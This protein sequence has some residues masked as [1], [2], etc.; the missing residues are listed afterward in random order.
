MKIVRLTKHQAQQLNIKSSLLNEK[1][2]GR[3]CISSAKKFPGVTY[4]E[5]IAQTTRV[6]I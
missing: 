2:T 3:I 6:S 5:P 4:P 1:C